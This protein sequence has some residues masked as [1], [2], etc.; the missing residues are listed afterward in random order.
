MMSNDYLTIVDVQPNFQ[1]ACHF[2]LPEIVEKI[3]TSN[4]HLI[5]F[6]VGKEL[7]GDTKDD[8]IGY[9]MEN[10]VD[11]DKLD[12]MKFIQKDFGFFRK[13][14]DAGIAESLIVKTV[15]YLKDRA[16]KSTKQFTD[17]DWNNLLTPQER[18]RFFLYD[19]EMLYPRFNGSLFQKPEVN[20][21]ELIGGAL[22][23]CLTEID[24]YLKSLGK[25]TSISHQYCYGGKR[26]KVLEKDYRLKQNK[27]SH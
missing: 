9:F 23:E 6:Y 12:K 25:R 22:Q 14:M 16:L 21:I 8:V 19:D 18:K 2:I 13:W 27:H 17:E 26:D 11:F 15:K 3:N 1:R 20:G 7:Q 4:Q 24:I 10:G 5:C